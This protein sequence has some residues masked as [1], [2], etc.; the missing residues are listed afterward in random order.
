MLK[1]REIQSSGVRTRENMAIEFCGILDEVVGSRL[2]LVDVG[3][4]RHPHHLTQILRAQATQSA[5][6][7][8]FE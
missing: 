8:S 7:G 1:H 2:A 5:Q 6:S 3:V 4:M